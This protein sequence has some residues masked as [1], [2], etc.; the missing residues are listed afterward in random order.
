LRRIAALAVILLACASCASAPSAVRAAPARVTNATADTADGALG[1]THVFQIVLEN[2]SYKHSYVHNP[3]HYLSRTLPKQGTLLTHYHG[4]G[5]YSLDNY[6]A[7]ISGQAPNKS[8][9]ADCFQYRNF[10]KTTHAATINAQGQAV[11]QGCVYPR[12][13]KTLGDQLTAN[14][15][16]WGGF[17]DEMG[18]TPSREQSRCGV[19]HLRKHKV[20]D[21][22]GATAKDQYAARHNPFVYFH[23][24]IDTGQ[25]KQN[26]VPLHKLR[27]ALTDET[28]TPQYTFITPDLCNDGHDSPCAGHDVAGSKA[29]GLKSVDHF[30][31]VWVPLIEQS[32]AFIDGGVLIITSDEADGGDSSSCCGEKPGPNETKPGLSGPGG[33]RIGSLV[34][35]KCVPAGVKDTT[36]YNHYSLLRTLEDIFGITT[37]GTD[38][39]GHLGYAADSTLAPFGP[40]VFA[41]CP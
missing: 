19:P 23:S 30:L 16:T 28:T 14:A 13:V 15:V 40:D 9:R 11:G 17:M 7:M 35:G 32:P 38:G 21:T 8:T 26:V 10:N 2:E 27:G 37:G 18:N 24:L 4:I 1:I 22:Q 3:N 39:A 6:L 36:P 29:G 20:D 41:S 12:N 33:G 5:H 25:C 31:K 34:I